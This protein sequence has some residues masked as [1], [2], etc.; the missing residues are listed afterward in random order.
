VFAALDIA[1]V[2]SD[3]G[4]SREAVAVV[5]F[6]L[7]RRFAFAWLRARIG[8]LPT[9]THWQALAKSAL[10]D[11]LAGLHRTLTGEVFARGGEEPTPDAML[12]AWMA[13]NEAALARADRLLAELKDTPAADLAMLSVAIAELRALA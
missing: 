12:T 6:A 4:R 1:E 7:G 2:A 9:E 11:Q 5:H 10:R 3:T 13:R 8:Q